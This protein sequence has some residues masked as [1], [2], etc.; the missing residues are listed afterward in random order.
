M[1]KTILFF[2]AVLFLTACTSGNYNEEYLGTWKNQKTVAKNEKV[3]T[4]KADDNQLRLIIHTSRRTR[5]TLIMEFIDNTTIQSVQD[6]FGTKLVFKLK[7]EDGE[8]ILIDYILND[9][10]YKTD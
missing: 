6:I 7:E 9:K 4:E 2:L 5:Q 3:T 8:A 1:K 10:Y